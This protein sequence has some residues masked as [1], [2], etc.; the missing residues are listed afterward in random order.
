M[1]TFH[2]LIHLFLALLVNW[3]VTGIRVLC[4]WI[5]DPS[6]A[7]SV[8]GTPHMGVV[9]FG[10]M[11]VPPLW[12]RIVVY[13]GPLILSP[14]FVKIFKRKIMWLGLGLSIGDLMVLL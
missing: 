13:L 12:E 8:Y 4:F 5:G 2:E 1:L 6:W 7:Y 9:R 3:E 11:S 10:V 14:L